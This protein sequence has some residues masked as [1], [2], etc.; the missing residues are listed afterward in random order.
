MHITIEQADKDYINEVHKLR[1]LV[2]YGSTVNRKLVEIYTKY[3]GEKVENKSCCASERKIFLIQ[4]MEWYNS[5][6]M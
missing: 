3:T 2:K 6:Q 4:F 1:D 5:L